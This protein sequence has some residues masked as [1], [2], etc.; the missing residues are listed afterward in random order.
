MKKLIMLTS[1]IVIIISCS[2]DAAHKRNIESLSNVISYMQSDHQSYVLAHEQILDGYKELI[3]EDMIFE[4]DSASWQLDPEHQDFRGLYLS[5]VE[6]HKT[7]IDQHKKLVE[8]VMQ[9]DYEPLETEVLEEKTDSIAALRSEYLNQQKDFM[10]QYNILLEKHQ[11][12]VYG[13]RLDDH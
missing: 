12:F 3:Q 10:E 1:V 7:F 11:S 13:Q 6:N 9:S 8:Q 2:D 5:M 4:N